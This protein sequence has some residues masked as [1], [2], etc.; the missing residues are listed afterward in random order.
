MDDNKKLE[1][2][3][4]NT[5]YLIDA[6]KERHEDL[7]LLKDK[8]NLI[9][10]TWNNLNEFAIQIQSIHNEIISDLSVSLNSLSQATNDTKHSIDIYKK[11][12]NCV[13]KMVFAGIAIVALLASILALIVQIQ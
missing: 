11:K 10:E 1:I 12:R 13:I 2:E 9:Q 6:V 5:K 7:V 4:N 3:I 8:I